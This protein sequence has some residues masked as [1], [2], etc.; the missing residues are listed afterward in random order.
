MLSTKRKHIIKKKNV[1]IKYYNRQHFFRMYGNKSN[2]HVI[3]YTKNEL[4]I[5]KLSYSK[6]STE[7][8]I[9]ILSK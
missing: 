5:L 7:F 3:R 2:N 9:K 4:K 1:L 8:C 6:R